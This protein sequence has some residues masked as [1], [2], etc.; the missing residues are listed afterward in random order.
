VHKLRLGF[1]YTLGNK[2]MLLSWWHCARVL[3]VSCRLE[4]SVSVTQQKDTGRV[5]HPTAVDVMSM[6]LA[7]SR[8]AHATACTCKKEL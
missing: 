1:Q 7:T 2:H 3:S 5:H 4:L 6:M 8:G